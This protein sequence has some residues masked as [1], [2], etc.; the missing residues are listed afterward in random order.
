M[1]EPWRLPM[2]GAR[3]IAPVLQDKYYPHGSFITQMDILS[4]ERLCLLWVSEFGIGDHPK[5]SFTTLQATE[6]NLDGNTCLPR[7]LDIRASNGNILLISLGN[8]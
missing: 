2:L 6:L 5:S 1:Y 4:H 3:M 7:A 8:A